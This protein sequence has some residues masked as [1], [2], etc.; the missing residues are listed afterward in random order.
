MARQIVHHENIAWTQSGEKQPIDELLKHSCC[1][2]P[3]G[4]HRGATTVVIDGLNQRCRTPMSVGNRFRYALRTRAPAIEASHIGFWPRFSSRK[5]SL[6][7]SSRQRFCFHS[8]RNFLT[9]ERSCSAACNCFF[10]SMPHAMQFTPNRSFTAI[11]F[12]LLAKLYEC[13]AM[14]SRTSDPAFGAGYRKGNASR[15]TLCV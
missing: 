12:D 14:V 2:R 3:D 1:H 5:T 10:K 13:Q 4:R 9:S 15:P 8:R 6:R 11:G 7:K